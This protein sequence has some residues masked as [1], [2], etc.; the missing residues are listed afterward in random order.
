MRSDN[1]EQEKLS[2]KHI[3][4]L[5]LNTSTKPL[6]SPTD[7]KVYHSPPP[8]MPETTIMPQNS[9]RHPNA[10]CGTTQCDNNLHLAFP[11]IVCEKADA[12]TP[13]STR[14][15]KDLMSS[16]TSMPTAMSCSHSRRSTGVT[17]SSAG[18]VGEVANCASAIA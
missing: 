12:S 17:G 11:D 1:Y 4:N 15:A 18:G 9:Q 14:Q 6:Q 13:R 2:I 8:Q 10:P 5:Q 16:Y 3:I 7:L